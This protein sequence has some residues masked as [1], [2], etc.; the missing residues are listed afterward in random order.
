VCDMLGNVAELATANVF[1]GRDGVVFTPLPNGTF[2][3]GVTRQRVI[4]LLRQDGIEVVET[5]LRYQDFETAD[6]I[7]STGNYSKV[8]PVVR[9]DDRS[10]QPGPL[11]R[12]ARE[13]Y[14]EFAH[15]C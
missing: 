7:F 2:L 8:V 6:E 4:K 11:Y 15:S 10:L 13:L 5:T 9:I 14:W 12:R 1:M 3:N